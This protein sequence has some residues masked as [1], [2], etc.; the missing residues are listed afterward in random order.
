[1]SVSYDAGRV[2]EGSGWIALHKNENHF[3]SSEWA[4]RALLENANIRFDCY[5]DPFSAGIREE[6]AKLYGVDSSNIY[7][8]NG[9]DGVL[10]DILANRSIFPM[11]AIR[12]T[13][14]WQNASITA[15]GGTG[16]SWTRKTRAHLQDFRS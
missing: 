8:G 10:A 14:F 16:V 1:M 13:T 7:V 15:L 11:S 6:L 4:K 5:P 12:S 3:I 9:S 2:V